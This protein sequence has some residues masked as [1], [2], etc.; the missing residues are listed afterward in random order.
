MDEKVEP[1]SPVAP[2][3]TNK[4]YHTTPQ[5]SKH[6]EQHEQEADTFE[7]VDTYPDYFYNSKGQYASSI[8]R[9]RKKASGTMMDVRTTLPVA[10][11]YG[12]DD[13]YSAY[14]NENNHSEFYQEVKNNKPHKSINRI[15]EYIK[16]YF[17]D[18]NRTFK[19][20]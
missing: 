13:S 1:I 4:N 19:K 20:N 3:N 18:D 16:K 10:P 14:I 12:S 7:H 9:L 2:I 6:D 11:L 17:E 15:E 5:N 8:T